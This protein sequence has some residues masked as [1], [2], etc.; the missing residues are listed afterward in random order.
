MEQGEAA[1]RTRG[2]LRPCLQGGSPHK[3]HYNYICVVAATVVVHVDPRFL[4][5]LW[6]GKQGV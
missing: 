4:R 2:S 1:K 6:H 5:Y 3:D